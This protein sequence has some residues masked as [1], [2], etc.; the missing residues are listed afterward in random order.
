[1]SPLPLGSLVL[2]SLLGGLFGVVVDSLV[3]SGSLVDSLVGSNNNNN[4]NNDIT[5]N[6]FMFSYDG[7]SYRSDSSPKFLGGILL[8]LNHVGNTHTLATLPYNIRHYN[9]L[10]LGE[11]DLHSA[12]IVPTATGLA[13]SIVRT[14]VP[15]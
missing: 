14:R 11:F 2:G 13:Y 15:H 9:S 7:V 4:N 10:D 5:W 12:T 8:V 1:M 3:G 6:D